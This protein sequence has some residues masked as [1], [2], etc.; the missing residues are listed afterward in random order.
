M[1]GTEDI[2]S[3]TEDME[4]DSCRKTTPEITLE[5]AMVSTSEFDTDD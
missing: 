5:T 3:G 1:S 4:T 2:M